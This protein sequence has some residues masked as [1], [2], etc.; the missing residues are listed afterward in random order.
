MKGT[1]NTFK[2]IIK[3]NQKI[4]RITQNEVS[5]GKNM[6]FQRFFKI[7][8]DAILESENVHHFLLDNFSINIKGIFAFSLITL[9]FS[10]TT[11]CFR[12]VQG[13][14]NIVFDFFFF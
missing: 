11:L 8:M 12:H 10:A 14:E 13:F 1:T 4:K 9:K 7:A 2:K 3:H 5:S 6:V